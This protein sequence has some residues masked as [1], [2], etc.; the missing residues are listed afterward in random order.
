[1]NAA[2]EVGGNGNSWNTAYK[3]LEKAIRVVNPT[4]Q[5]P[6]EI[7]VARGV[8]KPTDGLHENLADDRSI[9]FELKSHLTIRGGF[10]GNEKSLDERTFTND[11]PDPETN[12]TQLNQTVL[13]GDIGVRQLNPFLTQTSSPAELTSEFLNHRG[14]K[15]NSFNVILAQNVDG[16]KLENIVIANGYAGKNGRLTSEIKHLSVPVQFE[17]SELLDEV[18]ASRRLGAPSN[19]DISKAFT[20]I[21]ESSIG[22][23]QL[24]NY[25]RSKLDRLQFGRDLINRVAG[26]GMY[27]ENSGRNSS[28]GVELEKCRFINNFTQGYGAGIALKHSNMVMLNSA[29]ENNYSV[30]MG[31]AIFS[32]TSFTYFGGVHFQGNYSYTSGGAVAY[33]TIPFD[34]FK[35]TGIIPNKQTILYKLL[36]R[37]NAANKLSPS[38]S[39]QP[40]DLEEEDVAIGGTGLTVDTEFWNN[41]F[42]GIEFTTDLAVSGLKLAGITEENRGDTTFNGIRFSIARFIQQYGG[43]QGS[44]GNMAVY[45]AAV[46]GL[47]VSN[48]YVQTARGDRPHNDYSRTLNDI[49]TF[50]NS[51]MTPS[52]IAMSILFKLNKD[53]D[54]LSPSK[55]DLNEIADTAHRFTATNMALSFVRK[56]EFLE[57]ISVSG[58]AISAFYQPLEIDRTKIQN[59]A[60]FFRG[61]GISIDFYSD[62]LLKN[63]VINDGFASL[64]SAVSANDNVQVIGVNNTIRNNQGDHRGYAVES[65]MNSVVKIANSILWDNKNSIHPTGGADL[66]ALRKGD[67]E[68]DSHW[69]ELTGIIDLVSSNVQSLH[70]ISEGTSIIRPTSLSTANNNKHFRAPPYGSAFQFGYGILFDNGLKNRHSAGNISINPNFVTEFTFSVDSPMINAGSNYEIKHGF[71]QGDTEDIYN[72]PRIQ[73]GTVDM[74]AVEGGKVG[75]RI[76]VDDTATGSGSGSSWGNAITELSYAL[77]LAKQ[78]VADQLARED[79]HIGVEI[80]IA[81]GVYKPFE[82]GQYSREFFF[83]IPQYVQL[84]GGFRG[85]ESGLE[86]RLF[87]SNSNGGNSKKT[88]YQTILSGDIGVPNDPT[89]NCKTVVLVESPGWVILDGLIIR[90]GYDS[91]PFS[92]GAGLVLNNVEAY[93][94]ID[95][96]EVFISGPVVSHC[97]IENNYAGR[98]GGGL[99]IGDHVGTDISQCI[100]SG[101]TA[102]N[103]GGGVFAKNRLIFTNCEFND[104][105]AKHGGG[106]S[107]IGLSDD[108]ISLESCLFSGNV[109]SGSTATGAALFVDTEGYFN[110]EYSTVVGNQIDSN[111]D[112]MTGGVGVWFDGSTNGNLFIGSS[113]FWENEIVGTGNNQPGIQHQQIYFGDAETHNIYNNIIPGHDETVFG[114]NV[115]LGSRNLDLD[116][117]FVDPAPTITGYRHFLQP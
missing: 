38:E 97:V 66:N 43:K 57:N 54:L 67:L 63:S 27:I 20:T 62:I 2:I 74:G 22:K 37:S 108:S 5:N 112:D 81:E 41:G 48:F 96:E 56:C 101:N 59:N 68:N 110:L 72:L 91:H 47:N 94:V 33:R 35:F 23:Q 58:G 84:Y 102:G 69:R 7:W 6:A 46:I 1:M 60:A 111:A 87:E 34:E 113:I 24:H 86:E 17:V 77:L 39:Y 90:D 25:L 9:S 99:F 116:P 45:E 115:A 3:T 105:Q 52:G 19:G 29:F 65:S 18:I 78:R 95:G 82:N 55:E 104:N 85:T 32:E 83:D 64:G 88:Q 10:R 107:V 75:N 98:D 76:Y 100:F 79:D 30:H 44:A 15:D 4:K 31:G 71:V 51:Y 106:M 13:S 42:E 11:E 73:D 93:D 117:Y 36:G 8:Y 80:F 61:G 50:V 16:V 40:T 12:T 70:S 21:L 28:R 89:D 103:R 92:D 26:G 49:T 114:A 14:L 53:M 109:A